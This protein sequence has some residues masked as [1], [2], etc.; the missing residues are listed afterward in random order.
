MDLTL[1]NTSNRLVAG[2]TGLASGLT[3]T[4]LPAYARDEFAL[5]VELRAGS[6]V[7]R[8]YE[9]RDFV[10]TVIHFTLVFTP[11]T[12]QPRAVVEDVVDNMLMHVLR[13]LDESDL[14]KA[15]EGG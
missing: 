8:R 5:T 6:D 7:L 10:V 2:L 4:L 12:S 9:Y 3:F 1:S 13:D 15:P 11:R 14:L